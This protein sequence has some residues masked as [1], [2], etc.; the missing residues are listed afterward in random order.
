MGLPMPQ[1]ISGRVGV[2]EGVSVGVVVGVLEF[3]VQGLGFRVGLGVYGWG[4]RVD[5]GLMV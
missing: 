3:G 4:L 5:L 2:L 1:F